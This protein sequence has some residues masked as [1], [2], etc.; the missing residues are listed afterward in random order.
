MGIGIKFELNWDSI[1][2]L[3]MENNTV[4]LRIF[5]EY[6]YLRVTCTSHLTCSKVYTIGGW[7]LSRETI[8]SMGL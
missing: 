8:T 3:Y 2:R 1:T 6:I 7:P 5:E 4:A